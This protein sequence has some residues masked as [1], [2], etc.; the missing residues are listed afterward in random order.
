[1]AVVVVGRRAGADEVLPPDHLALV[2]VEVIR[3]DPRVD[4]RGDH[5]SLRV[6]RGVA[7]RVSVHADVGPRLRHPEGELAGRV[8]RAAQ[9]LAVEHDAATDT[10][11]GPEGDP[12]ADAPSGAGVRLGQ[13][14]DAHVVVERDRHAQAAAE[15]VGHRHVV[16]ALQV[17]RR[18][19]HAALG[20]DRT[21]RADPDRA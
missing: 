20:V 1:V 16:P 17:R 2:E 5:V 15:L 19:Q 10:G 14:R 4:H 9:D 18:A 11:A 6:A 7:V 21:G 13:D 12:V 3:V 8:R